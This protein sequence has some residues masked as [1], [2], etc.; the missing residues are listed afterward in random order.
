MDRHSASSDRQIRRADLMLCAN[1]PGNWI[2]TKAFLADGTAEVYL[3]LDPADGI[4]EFALK[5]EE[6]AQTVLR[7]LETVL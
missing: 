1:P 4:G 5:D 6:Y 2:V 7:E 3:N